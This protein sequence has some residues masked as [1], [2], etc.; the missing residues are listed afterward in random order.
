MRFYIFIS[1]ETLYWHLISLFL[2]L[3]LFYIILRFKYINSHRNR[4]EGRHFY[5]IFIFYL[6]F[7][8]FIY[9]LYNMQLII[10][11][12]FPY[13]VKHARTSDLYLLCVSSFSLSFIGLGLKINYLSILLIFW[14]FL[15]LAPAFFV[16]YFQLSLEDAE[17]LFFFDLYIFFLL[18]KDFDHLTF[19]FPINLFLSI[20]KILFLS[21]NHDLRSLSQD[22]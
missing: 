9:L 14:I 16:L 18:L 17:S 2:I 22:T 21:T 6:I 7:K 13:L 15:I 1:N 4:S 12:I 11:I 20:T 5:F 10:S 19:L 8:G 3:S